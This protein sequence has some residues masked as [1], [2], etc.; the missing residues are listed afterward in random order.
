MFL[1]ALIV[2]TVILAISLV[3]Y[4]KRSSLEN[5]YISPNGKQYIGKVF[6][7]EYPVIHGAGILKIG[8]ETWRIKSVD[9]PAGARIK[10]IDVKGLV[11]IGEPSHG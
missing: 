4:L 1:S 6:T 2:V 5:N 10:I 3:W 11:L 7:L 8:Q 9:L